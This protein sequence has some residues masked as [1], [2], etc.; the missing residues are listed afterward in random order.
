MNTN[1][2]N[3]F[4]DVYNLITHLNMQWVIFPQLFQ[5][6]LINLELSLNPLFADDTKLS[7]N[8]VHKEVE[9]RL[10]GGMA[11]LKKWSTTWEMDRNIGKMWVVHWYKNYSKVEF[12]F[13]MLR[14][15]NSIRWTWDSSDMNHNVNMQSVTNVNI[16]LAFCYKKIWVKEQCTPI[17]QIP[18]RLY[19]ACTDL[20]LIRFPHLNRDVLWIVEV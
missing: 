14:D 12:Y 17:N 2:V 8:V 16:M 19:L 4:K 13:K 5:W 10:F 3:I 18:M 9:E 15:W 1:R 6:L 20:V 11:K 7:G